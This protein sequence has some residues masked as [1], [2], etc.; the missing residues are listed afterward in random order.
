MEIAVAPQGPHMIAAA[1]ENGA[2]DFT[3]CSRGTTPITTM[4]PSTYKQRCD[5]NAEDGRARDGSLGVFDV[6]RR[7]RR[8]LEPK[9]R[10]H[11]QRC[12]CGTGAEQR[13]AARVEIAEM[14]KVDI[15]QARSA[16]SHRTA[17]ASNTS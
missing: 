5:G 12:E 9:I 13:L 7:N 1:S 8:G 2:T 16:Q 15:K 14:G 17:R 4:V 10:K 3:S 6:V 11:R